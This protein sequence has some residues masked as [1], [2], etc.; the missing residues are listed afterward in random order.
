MAVTP[1]A[2][3]TYADAYFAERMGSDVWTST[4]TADKEKSL[5]HGT[6][7]IDRC[8][9][10]LEKTDEDQERE[11]PRN[12]DTE[13]PDEVKQANCEVALELLKGRLPEET[14]V[15]KTGIASES[16]GDTSRS[17]NEGGATQN[18]GIASGLPSMAAAQLL[19]DWLVN[20]EELDLIRVN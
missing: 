10:V 1:Y 6:R 15:K 4:E 11:F 3:V 14:M 12:G 18:I 8:D 2:D 17:Y 19:K 7:L 5:K 9:F 13:I 16:V 20:P